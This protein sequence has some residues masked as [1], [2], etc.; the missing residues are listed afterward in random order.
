MS[1]AA[2]WL[3][4]RSGAIAPPSG[5]LLDAAYLVRL[6]RGSSTRDVI[7]EFADSSAVVSNGYAEEVAR[8]FLGHDEPPRHLRVDVSGSVNVLAGPRQPTD[9]TPDQIEFEPRRARNHRRGTSSQ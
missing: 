3:I 1:A 6:T 5:S 9:D 7:V 4:S 8:R 2:G